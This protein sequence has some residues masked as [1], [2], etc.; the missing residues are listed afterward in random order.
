LAH[1]EIYHHLKWLEGPSFIRADDEERVA[2]KYAALNVQHVMLALG[3]LKP[4]DITNTVNT[5]LGFEY[6]GVKRNG[7]RIMGVSI[8][9]GFASYIKPLN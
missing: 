1:Q 7:D 8:A 3:K 9:A 2:V 4:S 6:A 5:P